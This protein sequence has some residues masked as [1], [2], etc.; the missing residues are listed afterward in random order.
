MAKEYLLSCESTVD[1]PYSVIHGRGIQVLFYTYNVDGVDYTDDMCR[2]P[3][4][5][6]RFYGFIADG[7]VPKTSQVNVYQYS[8]YFR[9]LLKQGDVLHIN[10]GSGMTPSVNNAVEAAAQLREEFPDRRIEVVDSLCSSSGYGLL[11]EE[12]ADRWD[13]GMGMDELIRWLEEHRNLV[14]HQFFTSD[15]QYFRRSGRVSGPAAAIATILNIC[16][17]LR[18][19]AE[20]RII[21]Y[22]KVRGKKNAIRT[23]VEA[24]KRDA[25]DGTAYN[26]K[27]FIC[28]ANALAD[29]EELKRQIAE[30]FPQLK[31]SIRIYDIGTIIASH[32]GPG[33]VAV[34]FMGT[35]RPI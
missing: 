14:H 33:T 30:S 13:A 32:C 1:M 2:E 6:K 12:A 18:L 11:V 35:E 8:E 19:N 24:M 23:T 22:D 27:T 9:S 28:H 5:L 15:I 4:A 31:D 25:L 7:K 21:A 16:P 29:A 20:G 3:E 34:F 26:G 17:I 10:F